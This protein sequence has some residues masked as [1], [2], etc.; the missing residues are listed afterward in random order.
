MSARRVVVE[1]PKEE[2]G[3]FWVMFRISLLITLIVL[4]SSLSFGQ[5]DP[6]LRQPDAKF[7]K[8]SATTGVYGELVIQ[9]VVDE[10]GKVTSAE[11]VRGP[12]PACPDTTNPIIVA[13]REEARK[14]ALKARFKAATGIN[15]Q[16]RFL[17]YAFGTEPTPEIGGPVTKLTVVGAQIGTGSSSV[18]VL[19]GKATALPQPKYPAAARSVRAG[20]AVQVKV[21]IDVDGTMLSAEAVSGH[22]LLQKAA[23]DAACSSQFL[24]TLLSGRPVKVSGIITYN[25]VP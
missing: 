1:K 6:D 21:L 9:V 20:G 5:N 15:S 23:I 4:S 10:R 17:T 11:F 13:A 24:P 7:P 19:N 12:G 14:A 25:F 18:G 8:D 16:P 2:C 3:N 22:P